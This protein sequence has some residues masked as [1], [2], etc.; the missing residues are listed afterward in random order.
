MITEKERIE[1]FEK[2]LS[3]LLKKHGA[4]VVLIDEKENGVEEIFVIMDM[5]YEP[6]RDKIIKEYAAINYMRYIKG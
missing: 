5:V 3:L 6:N 4:E 1:S 2:D